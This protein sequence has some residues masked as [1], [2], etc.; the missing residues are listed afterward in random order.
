MVQFASYNLEN[1]SDYH[2]SRNQDIH[3]KTKLDCHNKK[4]SLKHKNASRGNQICNC[5]HN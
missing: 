1:L 4:T 5:L 2:I 3:I